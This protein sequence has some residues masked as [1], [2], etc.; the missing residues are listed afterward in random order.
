MDL[1][2]V[3]S[4]LLS[5]FDVRSLGLPK[6]DEE[7]VASLLKKIKAK[8]SLTDSEKAKALQLLSKM[9]GTLS[10]THKKTIMNFLDN[11]VTQKDIET[12]KKIKRK[13]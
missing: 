5:N 10:P 9:S 6:K 1:S 13:L 4:T 7:L 8:K 3:I 12:V 11:N 2:S